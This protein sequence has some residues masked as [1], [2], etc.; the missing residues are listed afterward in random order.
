M[1]DL[2]DEHRLR[3]TLVRR[4]AGSRAVAVRGSRHFLILD[5]LP[6]VSAEVKPAGPI[7][8]SF[9]HV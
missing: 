2:H 7:P 4:A 5:E 3:V 1:G 8:T 9:G 6:V